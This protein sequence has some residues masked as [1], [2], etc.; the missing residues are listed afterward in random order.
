VCTIYGGGDNKRQE[1][2]GRSSVKFNFTPAHG[3]SPRSAEVSKIYK[4]KS[5]HIKKVIKVLLAFD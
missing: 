5:I 1:P 4:K 2:W 3:P